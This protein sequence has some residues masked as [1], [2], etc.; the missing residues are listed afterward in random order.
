LIPGQAFTIMLVSMLQ[1]FFLHNGRESTVN[2]MLNGSIY[3]V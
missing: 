2:T 1:N 3:P